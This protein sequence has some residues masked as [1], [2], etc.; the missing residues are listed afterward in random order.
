MANG[1]IKQAVMQDGRLDISA[2]A[3]YAYLCCFP[4]T[5]RK[6]LCDWLYI[7]NHTLTKYLKQLEKCGYITV[8]WVRTKGWASQKIMLKE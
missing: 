4:V 7:T 2:K 1:I 8:E 5:T 3:I 6:E